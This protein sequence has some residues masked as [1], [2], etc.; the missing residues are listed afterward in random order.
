M[1]PPADFRIDAATDA[2]V[3]V[4]LHLVRSLAEYEQ[5]GH[6]VTATERDVRDTLFGPAPAAEAAIARVGHDA[7]G[8]AVWF[9]TYS[10]FLARPGLYLEDVFVVSE[11]RGRG[12]GRAL[13]A[14]LARIAVARKCGRMEWSVLDW[15]EPAIRFYRALGARPLDE[16]TVF[17]VTG[18]ALD[19]LARS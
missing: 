4:L 2:D 13:L 9:F 8:F 10:T 17:R 15:N 14:H 3:P 19:R 1:P 7:V 6:A 11:W 18:D 16:W 12:I 5:L